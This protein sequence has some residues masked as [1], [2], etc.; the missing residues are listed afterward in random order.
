MGKIDALEPLACLGRKLP[1]YVVVHQIALGSRDF[2]EDARIVD[3]SLLELG[4]LVLGELAEQVADR[5]CRV[6][7]GAGRRTT[8]MELSSDSGDNEESCRFPADAGRDTLLE[9]VS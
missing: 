6:V 1:A 4:L 8:D 5:V 9:L 7:H 3:V 2:I